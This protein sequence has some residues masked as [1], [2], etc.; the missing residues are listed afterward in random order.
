MFL[1][2]TIFVVFAGRT[3]FQ[4]IIGIPMATNWAPLL[5]DIFLY[6]YEAE[7]IQSLLSAGRNR[8]ASQFNFTYRYIDGVLS[9]NNPD[10]DNYLGRMYPSELEI[11]DTTE[12]HFCFLLFLSHLFLSVSRNGQLRTSLDDKRND[13]Y[14]HITN[15]PFISSNI[16]SSPTCGVFISQPIRYARACSSYECFILRAVRLSNKLLGQGYVMERLKSSLKKFH[17]RYGDLTEQYEVPSPACYTT[18]WKMTIYS[19]T[20]Y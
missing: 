1:V 6:S 14:F 8:L 2:D 20:L 15:F 5:V 13:I 3:V 4:Q 16:P 12:Q 18:F 17:G 9:I 7:F 10:F 19:Y 11:K